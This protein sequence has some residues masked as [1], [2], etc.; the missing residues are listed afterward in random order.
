MDY[1]HELRFGTFLSPVNQPAGRPVE[2][3]R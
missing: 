1:G 3:A 2:L